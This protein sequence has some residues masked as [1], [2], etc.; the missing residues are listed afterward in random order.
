MCLNTRQIIYSLYFN[1]KSIQN[2]YKMSQI[3]VRHIL[4]QKQ[5]SRSDTNLETDVKRLVH[6]IKANT[7]D[8]YLNNFTD[9]QIDT[10]CEAVKVDITCS[11]ATKIKCIQRK[12]KR[13]KKNILL[14]AE[15]GLY[16]YVQVMMSLGVGWMGVGGV[17]GFRSILQKHYCQKHNKPVDEA[18]YAGSGLMVVMAMMNTP[19]FAFVAR[20]SHKKKKALLQK[21]N[22]EEEK[23]MHTT[24]KQLSQALKTIR[25]RKQ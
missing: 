15:I 12:I 9:S 4:T 23:H 21:L 5:N 18:K 6:A 3:N 24:I 14:L 22:N 13:K 10:F 25:K 8:E 11:R 19:F 7:L 16:R 17:A 20:L 1:I 2:Q